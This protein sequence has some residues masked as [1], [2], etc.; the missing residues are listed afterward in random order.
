MRFFFVGYIYTYLGYRKLG[1]FNN[2]SLE[3]L[4]IYGAF[5]NIRAQ[6]AANEPIG[7]MRR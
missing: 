5:K 6:F 2:V 1:M 7:L 3:R 4:I